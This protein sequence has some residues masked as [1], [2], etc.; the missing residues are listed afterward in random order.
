LPGN[1]LLVDSIGEGLEMRKNAK[2]VICVMGIGLG[3]AQCTKDFEGEYA[4]PNKVEVISDRWNETDARKTAEAMIKEMLSRP[5]LGNYSK[6]HQGQLPMVIVDEIENRTDEHIDTKELTEHVQSELINSGR[7]R[8]LNKAAR[9]KLDEELKYQESGKV[10]RDKA[11]QAGRR[12]GAGYML[13]GSLTSNVQTQA[14]LK[15]VT[16]VTVL[17]L[18]NLETEEIE[19][20]NRYAG[21]KK[22]FKR[23]GSSW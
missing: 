13:G 15:T 4:D 9:Q 19:W 23:S 6:A 18:T 21:I 12:L 8:F 20:T 1:A 14:G 16:Y 7:V 22:R 5:W 17:E 10:A 11:I 3:L 2:T